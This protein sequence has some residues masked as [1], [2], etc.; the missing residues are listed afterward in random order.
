MVRL[1]T[2]FWHS[3]SGHTLAIMIAR[4]SAPLLD[5]KS[6]GIYAHFEIILRYFP[7][8]LGGAPLV[9]AA[10]KSIGRSD[11][12]RAGVRSLQEPRDDSRL[13]FG[14][15]IADRVARVKVPTLYP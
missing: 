2:A 4:V 11:V 13:S 7:I 5:A 3:T 12:R 6:G 15:L 10:L 14:T 1:D 9:V 8:N